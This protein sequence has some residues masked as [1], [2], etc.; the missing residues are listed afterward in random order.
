MPLTRF[1][2]FREDPPTGRT[3]ASA[4]EFAVVLAHG[5]AG[6]VLVFNR[7]RRI[8]ELPG[9][10][11]DPGESARDCAQRELA[12]EAGC[13][14]DSLEWLGVV[15]VDDGRRRHGAVFACAV[16]EVPA[17]IRN[18]EI[19]GIS[20]WTPAAAPQPLGSTDRALLD[21][22]AHAGAPESNRALAK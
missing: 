16:T 14:S 6:V 3:D 15:E 21:R 13:I 8:W 4:L 2:A 9:G 17:R 19:E 11:I 12:E 7:H 1:I 20:A 10:L 18:E 22:L 5:P